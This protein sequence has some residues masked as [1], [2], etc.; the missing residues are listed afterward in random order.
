MVLLW[1]LVWVVVVDIFAVVELDGVAAI[2]LRV[3]L[4]VV[5]VAI[6]GCRVKN[7]SRH[8]DDGTFYLDINSRSFSR[9]D[10]ADES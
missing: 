10:R 1:V 9:G 2:L 6:S 5:V 8:V 4:S 7:S 3:L